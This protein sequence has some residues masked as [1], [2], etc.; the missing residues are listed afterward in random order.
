VL[1]R[2]DELGWLSVR[3]LDG[4]HVLTVDQLNTYD[5]LVNDDVVFTRDAFDALL[6]GP[7]RGRS[8]KAVASSTEV[9]EAEL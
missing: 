7:A 5:V 2:G 1:V 3:N 8:G 4:V 9:E 6:A